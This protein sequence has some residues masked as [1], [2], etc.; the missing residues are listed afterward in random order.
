MFNKVTRPDKNRHWPLPNSD[1]ESASIAMIVKNKNL[2][3]RQ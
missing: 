2:Q 1:N 3:V